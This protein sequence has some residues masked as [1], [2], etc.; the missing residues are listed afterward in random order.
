MADKSKKIEDS[1][2]LWDTKIIP[3][4]GLLYCFIHKNDVNPDSKEPYPGAFK[5]TPRNETGVDLSSDWDKYSTPKKTLERVGKHPKGDGFKNPDDYGVLHLPIE[6]IKS[7]TPSQELEHNPLQNHE[8]LPDN[9]A[10]TKIIGDK[11]TKVREKFMR[12]FK[13]EILPPDN[14]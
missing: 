14:N 13:W 3:K 10:H 7:N 4:K 5:N 12:M 11:T 1:E 9:Q 8:Y 6:K 2:N